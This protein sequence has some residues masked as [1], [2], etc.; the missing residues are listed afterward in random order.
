MNPNV[1]LYGLGGGPNV[2]MLDSMLMAAGFPATD[3][4]K[5]A[6]VPAQYAYS[7]DIHHHAMN[8]VQPQPASTVSHVTSG[9][10]DPVHVIVYQND[11]QQQQPISYKIPQLGAA[12][13]QNQSF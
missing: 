6:L 13:V 1:P 2:N 7:Q 10:S 8:L 4:P 5:P 9:A 12:V 11:N 3:Q